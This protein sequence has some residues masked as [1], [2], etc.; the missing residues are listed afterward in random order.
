MA[1]RNA[2]SL[3]EATGELLDHRPNPL[4]FDARDL[5]LD[6]INRRYLDVSSEFPWLF[7]Q[8]ETD[9][10]IYYDRTGE[11][12]GYTCTFV[13]SSAQIDFSGNL[14]T[15][16]MRDN[17]GC[18][19]IDSNDTVYQI[20]R[21][22]TSGGNTRAWLDALYTGSSGASSTW[23]LRCRRFKLPADCGV[24][25]GFIDREN[26]VG[27]MVVLDRRREEQYFSTQSDTTGTVYWLVED[28]LEFVRAPDPGWQA[29]DSTAGGSLTPLA[30][31][32]YAYT[33][34][35]QGI[36]SPPS[37]PLRITLSS[38]ANHT[39]QITGM[40]DTRV[41]GVGTGVYKRL[42]RR[43]LTRNS[44]T[45]VYSRWLLLSSSIA[46]STTTYND[47]GATTPDVDSPLTYQ[48]GRKWMRPKWIPEEDQTLRL[49]YVRRPQRLIAD[50]DAPIWPEA[51]HDLL[52]YGAAVDLAA[53]YGQLGKVQHW[54]SQFERM[55]RRM[56]SAHLA[57]PDVSTRK[58][59]WDH[60]GAWPYRVRGGVV[61]GDFSG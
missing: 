40:E 14:G 11:D 38:S 48:V 50:S 3:I 58:E 32:E 52:V 9:W 54:E 21:F 20:N 8:T 53:Q 5:R 26:G 30:T 51:Y 18:D 43:Q 39:V 25:L 57:V 59:R 22:T 6:A 13:N 1:F 7:L 12:T 33:L 34:Y 31:Y 19:F 61:D 2:K 16:F 28:D 45:V 24:P 56:K 55:L 46:E 4:A 29:A 15:A 27:R 42:Y 60:G 49:R 36:E 37:V 35:K 44:T 17:E 23:T 47:D 41:S 10:Y